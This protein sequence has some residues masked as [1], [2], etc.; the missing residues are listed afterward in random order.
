MRTFV[1]AMALWALI[2]SSFRFP[3]GGDPVPPIASSMK[4]RSAAFPAA[5]VGVSR[6]RRGWAT[7]SS[8]SVGTGR[9][10]NA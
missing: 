3:G 8:S 7:S 6:C 4:S 1:L 9:G 10:S 2:L 5:D